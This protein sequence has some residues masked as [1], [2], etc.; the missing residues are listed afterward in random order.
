MTERLR[1]IYSEIPRCESFADV[2]CDHGYIA[3]AMLDNRKCERAI[4]SDVSEKCLD[5]ARALLDSYVKEGTAEGRLSDGLEN[6]PDSEC[7]L[8][9]GMG[10]EEIIKILKNAPFSPQKLV[11]QPMKNVDKLRVFLV[12]FGYK[13][14]KDYVF[15]AE[16]RFYDLI[17]AELGKDEL[18]EEEREFGRTNLRIFPEAFRKRLSE[19]AARKREFSKN[20]DLSEETREKFLAEAERL[21][22]YAENGRNFKN[23]GRACSARTIL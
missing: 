19:E 14:V 5:K 2:G 9:A 17:A 21:E 23:S 18:S 8:I 16:N 1:V 11:L 3:K 13:I 4:F 20:P 22:K 7:V 15:F 6:L 10:G 12:N